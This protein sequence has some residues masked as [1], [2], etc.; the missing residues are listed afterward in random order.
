MIG[1]AGAGAFGTALAVALAR[2]GRDV[3]LWARDADQVQAMRDARR[4]DWAL[5]GVSLPKNV[6]IHA[7]ITEIVGGQALLLAVPMQA[8]GAVLD[9]YPEI[10]SHQ[11][12]VA[13]C[14]GVDLASLRGPVA[15]IRERRPGADAAILT[16]PSFAGDIAKGLPTA[17][18]LATTGEGSRLQELLSTP[19]LRLYRTDDITGAE[20]GGAL[21]NVIAIAAG[22]VIGAG[23]GD[24]ARAALMTR[25]YAEMVRLAGA[26]GARPETLAGLS[27][28]G[29]LVLTCTSA[30]S[31]NFRYGC[32]L[33]KA[34]AFDPSITVEGVATAR[35]VVRL[36]SEMRIDMPVTAMVDALAS[37]RIALN[38]AIGQL[39]SRPLKQE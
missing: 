15:L 3:R 12:L 13:C 11:T 5:P 25:G 18:T 21:K 27:G 14:K 16:G 26:M 2:A 32:A 4:N 7:E 22:T 31:R 35:A 36:A 10:G 30:Q 9:G 19:T 33:G 39:M 20:L 38:D 23:L 24:S 1:I 37:G 6:S 34:E 28:L 29:D 17:L 8:L